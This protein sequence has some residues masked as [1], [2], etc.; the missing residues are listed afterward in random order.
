MAKIKILGLVTLGVL[1]VALIIT[2]V[3]LATNNWA[4]KYLRFYWGRFHLGR[5]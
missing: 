3:A 1:V 5:N 2:I 4:S